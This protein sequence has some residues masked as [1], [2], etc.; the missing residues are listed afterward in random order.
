MAFLPTIKNTKEF[1]TIF[2]QTI[3]SNQWVIRSADKFVNVVVFVDTDTTHQELVDFVLEEKANMW[4]ITLSDVAFPNGA[5]GHVHVF[6]VGDRELQ[7]LTTNVPWHTITSFGTLDLLS[8]LPYNVIKL[9]F[10]SSEEL[11]FYKRNST[12]GEAYEEYTA[13]PFNIITGAMIFNSI[14]YD[15]VSTSLTLSEGRIHKLTTIQGSMDNLTFEDT[16]NDTLFFGLTKT[17]NETSMIDKHH[18]I[19]FNIE[20]PIKRISD[21]VLIQSNIKQLSIP[22]YFVYN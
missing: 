10:D 16:T 1:F 19:P 14:H 8:S 18:I 9:I 2:N 7:P 5:T 17:I 12:F 21:D 3:P 4:I 22:L 11:I 6:E 13:S 20:T 15:F